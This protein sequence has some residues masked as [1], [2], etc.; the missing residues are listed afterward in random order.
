MTHFDI[1]TDHRLEKVRPNRRVNIFQRQAYVSVREFSRGSKYDICF[2]A[3]CK[4]K[5]RV[6]ENVVIFGGFDH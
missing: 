3:R 4:P 5:N 6:S 2:S 1:Q